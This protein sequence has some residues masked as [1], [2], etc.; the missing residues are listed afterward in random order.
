MRT[1]FFS[2]LVSYAEKNKYAQGDVAQFKKNLATLE[3]LTRKS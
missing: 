1:E 2:K 3:Q